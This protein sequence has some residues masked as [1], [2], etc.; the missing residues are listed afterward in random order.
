MYLVSTPRPSKKDEMWD[1]RT[2][3]RQGIQE[4]LLM[5]WGLGDFF[6]LAYFLPSFLPPSLPSFLPFPFC[7]LVCICFESQNSELEVKKIHWRDHC[8]CT[9]SKTLIHFEL[10]LWQISIIHISKSTLISLSRP[11]L[12]GPEHN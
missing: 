2:P 11:D 8:I 3:S 12:S 5:F 1:C 9:T 10:S 7:P 6:L 4:L